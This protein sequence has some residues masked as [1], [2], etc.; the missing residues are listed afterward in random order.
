YIAAK[1]RTSEPATAATV[2]PIPIPTT[3]IPTPTTPT[4]TRMTTNRRCVGMRNQ[5]NPLIKR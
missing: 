3:P 1:L 4:I 2:A 5:G